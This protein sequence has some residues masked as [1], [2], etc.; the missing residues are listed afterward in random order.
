MVVVAISYHYL[1]IISVVLLYLLLFSCCYRCLVVVVVAKK[2]VVWRGNG[3]KSGVPT[4][5]I[6]AVSRSII[7]LARFRRP[8]GRRI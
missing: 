4:G 2:P 5:T 1:V 8:F 7:S 6:G 3:V